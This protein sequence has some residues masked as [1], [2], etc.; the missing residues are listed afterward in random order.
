MLNEV[1][2]VRHSVAL[3][4][5]SARDLRVGPPVIAFRKEIVHAAGAAGAV[6]S[7]DRDWCFL[8]VLVRCFQN[9]L[10]IKGGDLESSLLRRYGP[11][12]KHSDKEN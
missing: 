7:G 11:A 12:D 4:V 5:W 1:I 8:Q 3:N 9:T 10:T 6:R 2:R